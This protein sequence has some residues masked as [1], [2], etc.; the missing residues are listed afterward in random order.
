M[1]SDLPATSATSQRAFGELFAT[2]LR[3]VTKSGEHQ[4]PFATVTLHLATCS[5]QAGDR[6]VTCDKTWSIAHFLSTECQL[7]AATRSL[8]L[9]MMRC[10]DA[11]QD[12]A[13][14]QLEPWNS[15]QIIF[16]VMKAGRQHSWEWVGTNAIKKLWIWC[17]FVFR[18]SSAYSCRFEEPH[19][20]A[21]LFTIPFHHL[22]R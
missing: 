20:H 16:L 11:C 7:S 10:I 19:F 17:W 1:L 22:E 18:S 6:D 21:A 14:V 13:H 4:R 15:L 2:S 5:R 9:P 8:T 3:R 12:L